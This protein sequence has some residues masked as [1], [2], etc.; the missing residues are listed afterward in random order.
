ML[1]K[2]RKTLRKFTKMK[3]F[4]IVILNLFLLCLILFSN[5]PQSVLTQS[6]S[7]NL[8]ILEDTQIDGDY[9]G[10]L[11]IDG[12]QSGS[13]IVIASGTNVTFRN[14]TIYISEGQTLDSIIKIKTGAKL[15]L[16]NV[17]IL[18]SSKPTSAI[19]ENNGVVELNNCDFP[20]ISNKDMFVDILNNSDE[21]GAITLHNVAEKSLTR[22]KLLQGSIYVDESTSIDGE[23]NLCLEEDYSV[24]SESGDRYIGRALVKGINTFAGKFL[25]NFKF[26]GAP[27][28]SAIDGTSEYIFE[29]FKDKY[30]LDYVGYLGDDL[31]VCDDGYDVIYNDGEKDVCVDTIDSGDIILTQFC[32]KVKNKEEVKINPGFLYEN[33]AYIGGKFATS[34]MFVKYAEIY[35]QEN[36]YVG[37]NVLKKSNDTGKISIV[38]QDFVLDNITTLFGNSSKRLFINGNVSFQTLKIKSFCERQDGIY[39][40]ASA[41]KTQNLCVS[42]SVLTTEENVETIYS[43]QVLACV[44]L[45][46]YSLENILTDA[47]LSVSRLA[48]TQNYGI[49]NIEISDSFSNDVK[50]ILK[51]IETVKN[52]SLAIDNSKL[53]YDGTDQ[54]SKCIPY[55]LEGETKVYLEE[56][57]FTLFKMENGTTTPIGQMIDAGDYRIIVGDR[58]G[59]VFENK[60]FDITIDP[61]GLSIEFTK[62]DFVYDGTEKY[63]ETTVSGVL[64]GESVQIRYNGNGQILPGIYT[65]TAEIISSNSNNYNILDD[66]KECTLFI[67]KAT[68]DMSQVIVED[69]EVEYTGERFSISPKNEIEGLGY[70]RSASYADVG[71]YHIQITFFVTD[72]NLYYPLKDNENIRNVLLKITPKIIDLSDIHFEDIHHT[73]DG[74]AINVNV[75]QSIIDSLP[76]QVSKEIKISGD[77]VVNASDTPYVVTITFRLRERYLK[78]YALSPAVHTCKIYIERATI[79]ESVFKFEDLTIEYDGDSH[80]IEAENIPTEIVQCE[81]ID[82]G[83]VV[84]GTYEQRF[85]LKLSDTENYNPL[86]KVEYSATLTILPATFDMSQVK[87]D[88][89]EVTYGPNTYYILQASNFSENLNVTYKYYLGREHLIGAEKTGVCNAGTYT[90]VASFEAKDEWK[91]NSYPIDDLSANLIINKKIIDLSSFV[92]ED[93]IITYDGLSHSLEVEDAGDISFEYSQ[94]NLVNAGRYEIIATPI[95]DTAN[96]KLK[97]ATELKAVLTIKKVIIDMSN[98]Q[99]NDI[100][101]TYDRQVKVAKI[102][103]D[104][105][106]GVSVYYTNNEQINA[107]EYIAIASFEL[108]DSVNFEAIPNKSCTIEINQKA[109][110]VNLEKTIFVYNGEPIYV[111]A[112]VEG[113]ID[114]DIVRVTLK[115]NGNINASKYYS[116][117][118]LSNS[119]YYSPQTIVSYTIEKTDL[120]LSKISFNDV[121][122]TYDGLEHTPKLEGELPSGVT[123]NIVSNKVINVGEYISYVEFLVVNPNY[124]TPER[125][126]AYSKVLPKPILVEFSN[127][128]NL[129]ADGTRH[130][131]SV[132]FVGLVDNNFDDYKL[133]YSAEP[134]LA[135]E[136]TVK[137]ELNE[138][139]NYVILGANT[140]NFEILTS[141]K[142]YIDQDLE[143]LIKG[144]GFSTTSNIV[145]LQNEKIEEK[146]LGAGIVPKEYSAFKLEMNDV[147]NRKEVSISLKP[148][149]INTANSKS[150]KV[151]KISN[152]ELTEID[153]EL[154]NNKINFVANLGDEIVVVEEKGEM[155]KNK[156][157]IAIIIFSAFVSIEIIVF[158]AFKKRHKKAKTDIFVNIDAE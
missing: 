60:Q 101:A 51:E 83:R 63:V 124:K 158:V 87:F 37:G 71:N 150:I 73:Y 22:I 30:Y 133:I 4:Y 28:E 39:E 127:Y 80:K 141:E 134:V 58:E 151:Y 57:E 122:V 18:L 154:K 144:D 146:L 86:K 79:D 96:Y 76:E 85:T 48:S 25:D 91:D 33:Y 139:S 140:L 75:P 143:I 92:F 62:T 31:R 117:I 120:D 126:V 93:K 116:E 29:K 66:S 74:N 26:D 21:I 65:I 111:T 35:E 16:D 81:N 59:F 2:Y 106:N 129:V 100:V 45:K 27:N 55:Y 136:Y 148:N 23:I 69:R 67:D 68:I 104:L 19:I 99:F 5:K 94:K 119:N 147:E 130:D 98:I 82:G 32:I 6:F 153:F 131:I 95:F 109:V 1:E 137:V 118:L 125:L 17:N 113:V 11:I 138:N 40:D 13:A 12:V 149:T 90:V 156:L 8:E 88:D 64:D 24:I 84:C 38:S 72:L 20:N 157:L 115:N 142:T 102:S 54:I 36:I 107:G 105:P 44:D 15:V 97:D 114:G 53:T 70:V 10:D 155:E 103:G 34:R 110:S 108:E 145:L 41:L 132:N 14:L 61:I 123:A 43:S 89:L 47:G 78:N 128:K 42:P 46:G 9:D 49:L 152:N 121:E 52:V 56:G 7:T 50:V 3:K 135:G 112:N 77:G